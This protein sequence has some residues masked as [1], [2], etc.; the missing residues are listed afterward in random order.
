MDADY[1]LASGYL[2]IVRDGTL[3]EFFG[4]FEQGDSEQ[5]INFRQWRDQQQQG[6]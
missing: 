3:M 6:I 1:S 5:A 2:F 4:Y